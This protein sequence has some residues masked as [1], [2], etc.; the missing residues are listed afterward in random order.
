M[1]Q[2]RVGTDED[3]RRA[4]D[5]AAGTAGARPDGAHG[6]M[7]VSGRRGG[8]ARRRRRWLLAAVPALAIG[9]GTAAAAL[10]GTDARSGDVAYAS[11]GA[12]E[13][14]PPIA[15]LSPVRERFETPAALPTRTGDEPSTDATTTGTLALEHGCVVAR[16]GSTTHVVVWPA[17]TRAV[18]E[19]GWVTVRTADGRRVGH[20]GDTVPVS[21]EATPAGAP[22][23]DAAPCRVEAD[24]PVVEARL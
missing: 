12:G 9:A 1:T 24:T 2:H 21:A 5:M 23:E 3:G 7:S 13:A 19:E 20:M 11:P 10:P 14:L 22:D 16:T 18:L 17:G 8:A 6:A 4:D 15:D